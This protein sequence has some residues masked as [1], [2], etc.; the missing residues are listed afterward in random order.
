MKIIMKIIALSLVVLLL[1]VKT[2]LSL[3]LQKFGK[4]QLRCNIIITNN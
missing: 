1:L 4:I 3:K 2:N